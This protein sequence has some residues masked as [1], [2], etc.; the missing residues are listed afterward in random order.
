MIYKLFISIFLCFTPFL[1]AQDEMV[2][3]LSTDSKLIPITL[4]D[5]GGNS[6]LSSSYRNEVKEILRFDLNYNG[7]SQITNNESLAKYYVRAEIE[8]KKLTLYLTSKNKNSAKKVGPLALSGNMSQDRKKIHELADL[9][10][11]AI[12]GSEGVATSKILYTLKE[13]NHDPSYKSKW[14][15][16]VWECDYDGANKRKVTHEKRYILSPVY[17]PPKPGYTPGTIFFV[18]YTTGQPRVHIASLKDGTGSRIISLKGNQLMPAVS[19]QRDRI[20]FISDIGGNPD[21]FIQNFD[22]EEGPIGKPRQL[23]ATAKGT[24]GC[25]TFSPDGKKIAFVSNKDGNPRVYVMDIP[26]EEILAKDMNPK[27]ITKR[28]KESTSP[29]WSP[30]GTM[31]AYSGL[32]DG[33]R[34]IWIYNVL[35]KEEEQLTYGPHHKENPSWAPDSLHLVY[36]GGPEGKNELY[37]VNLNQSEE[38]KI[39]SGPGDKRFPCWEPR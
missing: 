24:Q 6:G 22:A 23:F 25:P 37:I 34:Q 13:E 38:V 32:T 31:I 21:L 7:T 27:M 5:I 4:S 10:H 28:S 3:H 18:A 35:S 33:V 16:E 39:T 11:R 15:S 26:R 9:I 36:N 1:H 14:I 30:D 29:C 2:V 12:D 20:A 19:R 17:L 8:D